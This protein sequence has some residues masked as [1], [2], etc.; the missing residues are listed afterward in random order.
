MKKVRTHETT[1]QEE[2]VFQMVC[3]LLKEMG[4]DGEVHKN[5]ELPIQEVVFV[6]DIYIP[7]L[8]LV[9]AV[10]GR[11]HEYGYENER[12]QK[13][14][15]L[16]VNRDVLFKD[17]GIDILVVHNHETANRASLAIRLR[18][19]LNTLIKA[20]LDLQ[21]LN[22]TR[23]LLNANRRQLTQRL[24]TRFKKMSLGIAGN[25]YGYVIYHHFF[26]FKV[27]F[28]KKRTAKSNV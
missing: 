17:A 5:I 28:R 25:L 23:M 8:S 3:A 1:K 9:I 6:P 14:Q 27:I 18:L 10:D 26:G 24:P 21:R 15:R 20:P 16:D 7:R 11:I 4:F 2:T 12:L 19:I 13:Q 22:R